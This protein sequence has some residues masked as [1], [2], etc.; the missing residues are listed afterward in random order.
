M[1]LNRNDQII[2]K[3]VQLCAPAGTKET[4]RTVDVRLN[5]DLR[6]AAF[7]D[8]IDRTV[9]YREVQECLKRTALRDGD[10]IENLTRAILEGFPQVRVVEVTSS[11]GRSYS[12]S[13]GASYG[14]RR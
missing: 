10:L 4:C 7:K 13:R 6:Q 2:L 1:T 12:R 3:G 11:R 8:R 9:D 14:T 5:L